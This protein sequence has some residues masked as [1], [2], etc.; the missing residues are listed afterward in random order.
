MTRAFGR[1]S[2]LAC[3]VVS[4]GA[5]VAAGCGE[6]GVISIGGLSKTHSGTGGSSA[7][8]A[9]GDLCAGSPCASFTGRH[10]FFEADSPSDADVVFANATAQQGG[11]P[12]QPSIVYPSHETMFPINVSRIR[13]EWW[14]GTS[15]TLFMLAFVGPNTEVHVFTRSTNWTPSSDE[16]DWIA[17]SNRG[18][19]VEFSVVA[20]DELEPTQSFSSTPIT[21]AFSRSEVQGAI[22][23]WSTGTSGVMKALVSSEVPVK[24]YTDPAAADAATCVACHTLSRDGKRM[25]MGYDGEKLREISVPDKTAILP[26]GTEVPRPA[27]WATFSPDGKLL[28]IAR[29]G[30]LTLID[31]DTGATVGPNGGLVPLPTGVRATHPD[32][33][34]LGDQ[35]AVC[36]GTRGGNKDVEGGSIAIIPYSAG[37]WGA[38]QVLVQSTGPA[39]NNYY[40]VFSPDSRSIVY[41]RAETK[42]KDAVTATLRLIPVAG[43]TPIDLSRLNGRVNNVDGILGIGNTMPTWAPSSTPGVFWLAFSSLRQYATLRPQDLQSDQLWI[44]AID[45]TRSDPGY[46]AFWAPFQSVAE[47]NHRAFWTRDAADTECSCVEACGDG[48]DND[49][50]GAADELDCRVCES[51]EACGDG[52]DNDCDCVVDECNVELCS[53]SVDDDGDDLIDAADPDC[54]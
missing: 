21:L 54:Q 13:H 8:G 50:D 9:G 42:S 18:A 37:A 40:P 22:Y 29:D 31:A 3:V 23:Y 52:V 48:V 53:N 17:E 35:V 11:S 32:W 43:G 10:D 5:G 25:A 19:D 44:A 46:S 33:S 6:G 26:V 24:F 49:C 47:G 28:L 45:L 16:W 1:W 7:G 2:L 36:F 12:N 20:L 51:T 15:N 39:D 38:A 4:A 34:A 30:V 27:S 41:V 14:P